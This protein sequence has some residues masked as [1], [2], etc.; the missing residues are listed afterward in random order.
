MPLE[1][2][3]KWNFS[4]LEM[5]GKVLWRS[6]AGAE[7]WRWAGVNEVKKRGKNIL[8]KGWGVREQECISS[9]EGK[10]G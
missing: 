9:M 2:I 3:D 10:D 1:Y 8:G 5:S 7:T 6:D 4:Y